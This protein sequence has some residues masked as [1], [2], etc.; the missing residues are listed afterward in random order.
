MTTDTEINLKAGRR[1]VARSRGALSGLLLVILGAWA[2]LIPF[3]GPYFKF[4]I[5]PRPNES[6]HW[7]SGRGWLEVLPGVVAIVGGL[8]L[9]LSSSRLMTLL[10]SWLGAL[11]GIWLIVGTSLAEVLK[12]NAG[13]PRASKHPGLQ[14][15]ES[16]LYFF[17]IGAAIL[18]VAAVALGRLS[19]HSVRD[20]RAAEHRAELAAAE[21]RRLAEE[22]RVAA[23]EA[24]AEQRRVDE[25]RAAEQQAEEQRR[26]TTATAAGERG[27]RAG[28]AG[29]NE[30]R[31][32]AP[33]READR[34]GHVGSEGHL[35]GSGATRAEQPNPPA[36]YPPPAYPEPQGQPGPYQGQAPAQGQPLNQEQPG[37]DPQQP[38]PPPPPDVERR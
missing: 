29:E 20:V 11:A 38:P 24:V 13:S 27:D 35:A 5:N 2:A 16:L 31:D 30:V 3:V 14:A 37:F 25:R 15:L 17:A 26:A 6:W 36:G 10:G 28:L 7:T 34:P 18:L 33:G 8:L 21:E 23:E 12:I 1:R 32:G 19:V 22:R 9:L 4:G